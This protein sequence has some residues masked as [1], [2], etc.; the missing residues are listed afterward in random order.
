M[1][2][3]LDTADSEWYKGRLAG[4]MA[5]VLAV[6]VALFA[7]LFFIQVIKGDEYQRLSENN[8]IRLQNINAARGLIFDRSGY[9]LVDNRPAF[10]LGITVKDAKPLAETL[11]KLT[12]HIDM[13]VADI[14]ARLAAD[15]N[16]DAYEPVMLKQ[17]IGRDL[18]AAI[19]V[20]R[21]DLPGVNIDVKPRRHY[22]YEQS[23]AHLMGYLGEINTDELGR[24][25][26][27]GYLS[28]DIIGKFG[29]EK[30]YERYLKGE[31]GGRQ[32]E[33]DV[34]GRVVR[35]LDTR[36]AEAG[37]NIHLTLDIDL[38]RKAEALMAD[39]VGA[40][41]AIEPNSGEILAMVSSP[42]FNQ[43]DFVGG[44]SH[45]QWRELISN[46][47]RP[48][49]NK[50]IQGEY[51]PASTY[52]IV[53]AMA[54][55]GEA[56]IDENTTFFCP[57]HYKFGDRVFRCWKKGGHGKLSIRQA[58]AQSCD[59][60]FYQVGLRLGVDRLAWYAKG[61]GLGRLTGV[62]LDHEA[63]GLIP[64][65][66]WKRQYTGV[67]WQR[68]ETLSVAIGQGYNL[69]T[70]LQMAVLTAA[71]ANGGTLFR[72][73]ILKAS[74]SADGSL[75][76]EVKPH[77]LGQLPVSPKH[78]EIIRQGLWEVV[79]GKRGTAK[80]SRIEGLHMSG[81][82]GTAQVFSRKKNEKRRDEALAD[83]LK[84]HAWFVAY[85]PSQHPKIAISVLVEHGEHGSSGASPIAKELVI[86]Y[87]GLSQEI[88]ATRSQD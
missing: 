3:Y 37:N 13:P 60:Y 48:M 66:A 68:G 46:P 81:K 67:S 79:N 71:V 23:A 6:F 7:R 75:A 45:K 53:T 16:P 49:E 51:P 82:T 4:T 85:A 9:M 56:V 47:D 64:T 63:D 42:A 15:K 41:V 87:L 32:V 10:D 17:D 58:I 86:S 54:G 69:T 1:G 19:E 50:A 5:C 59:V 65:A 84:A 72:P 36:G 43:N 8:C 80:I 76:R 21:F 2:N 26:Y 28:G 83:H 55:L 78:L 25:K 57:G 38:Q 18:L 35:V 39:K 11:L 61:S 74:I 27:K 34:R 24:Q 33:V 29:V 40:V 30:S 70:P 52:K 73:Q 77:V 12:R 88:H 22:I 31:R 20:H 44:L 62:D 14:R